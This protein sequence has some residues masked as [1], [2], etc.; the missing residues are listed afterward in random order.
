VDDVL[1][2]V[3]V[4][5][6]F[7][8]LLPVNA[9]PILY[10]MTPWWRTHIGRATMTLFAGLAMLVD[11]AVLYRLVAG[12]APDWLR[13]VVYGLIAAG[14]Y[15]TLWVLVREQFVLPRRERRSA[16]R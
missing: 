8:M 14:L 9:F 12:E 2:L 6:L 7:S 3:A 5:L 16:V 10:A 13:V 11:F 1:A 4:V 15:Y